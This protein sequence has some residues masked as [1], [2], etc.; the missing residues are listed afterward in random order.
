MKTRFILSNVDLDIPVYLG[1]C[2]EKNESYKCFRLVGNSKVEIRLL[3]CTHEEADD[4]LPFHVNHAVMIDRFE[5]VLVCS[6]DT[7][8]Y[9]TLLYNFE[10]YWKEG[11]LREL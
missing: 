4:R 2:H 5:K 1:G 7:D 8:V 3:Y 6:G 11:G 10:F 9:T